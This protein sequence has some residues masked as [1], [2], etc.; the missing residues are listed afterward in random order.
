MWYQGE[1]ENGADKGP[2]EGVPLAH[3][4]DTAQK[5]RKT[6][7]NFLKRCSNNATKYLKRRSFKFVVIC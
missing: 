4:S 6:I 7:G 1:I 2:L 3:A 5:L